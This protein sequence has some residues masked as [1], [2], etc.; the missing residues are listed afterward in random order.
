MY[1]SLVTHPSPTEPQKR[2]NPHPPPNPPY[3]PLHTHPPH[4]HPPQPPFLTTPCTHTPPHTPLLTPPLLTPPPPTHPTLQVFSPPPAPTWSVVGSGGR[5]AHA[6]AA[7]PSVVRELAPVKVAPLTPHLAERAAPPFACAYTLKGHGGA[8]LALA[9]ARGQLFSASHDET[10]R[11]WSFGEGG[12]SG[13]GSEGAPQPLPGNRH[14]VCGHSGA[15]RALAVSSGGALLF[16]GNGRTHLDSQFA[17]MSHPMCSQISS[18]GSPGSDDTSVRV[19]DAKALAPLCSLS[20]H[21]QVCDVLAVFVFAQFVYIQMCRGWWGY[22]CVCVFRS[23]SIPPLQHPLQHP[24]QHPPRR[25]TAFA[26]TPSVSTLAQPIR[27]S[28]SGR[29]PLSS[30]SG[31]RKNSLTTH[32]S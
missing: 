7:S 15:V 2:P 19:W 10:V 31:K 26:S 6:V 29:S 20:G 30:A 9:R 14:L 28:A 22:G 21:K 25:C 16:T 1:P 8:V 23:P 5:R 27:R 18:N 32:D 3:P 4:T 17:H 12:A 24:P 11:G 13:G